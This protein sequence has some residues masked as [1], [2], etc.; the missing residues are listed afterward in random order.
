MTPEPRICIVTNMVSRSLIDLR[1]RISQYSPSSQSGEFK[2]G[3]KFFL[4]TDERHVRGREVCGIE[5]HNYGSGFT[6]KELS[7]HNQTVFAAQYRL[8][9]GK[10]RASALPKPPHDPWDGET[11]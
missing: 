3:S 9:A 7:Q 1:D 2:D 6:V 10:N 11:Y 5:V 4:A 8:K